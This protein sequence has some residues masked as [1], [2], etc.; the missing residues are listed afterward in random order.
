MRIYQG[1]HIKSPKN[2]TNDL[3][4][5]TGFHGSTLCLIYDRMDSC[6]TMFY[7]VCWVPLLYPDR[8][9]V[10]LNLLRFVLLE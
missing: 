3:S 7:L 5:Y 9:L 1:D 6:Y 4:R 10:W 8:L 2:L